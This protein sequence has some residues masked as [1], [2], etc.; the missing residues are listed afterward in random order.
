MSCAHVHTWSNK[1][2]NSGVPSFSKQ[3]T[4]ALCVCVWGSMCASAYLSVCVC[5]CRCSPEGVY[6]YLYVCVGVYLGVFMY[7]CV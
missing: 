1:L 3:H 7:T 2:D 5:V 4:V 6:V